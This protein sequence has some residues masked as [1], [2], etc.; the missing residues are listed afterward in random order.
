MRNPYINE[1]SVLLVRSSPVIKDPKELHTILVF[2]LRHLWGDL[3]S[4][5]CDVLVRK[6]RN[7]LAN[8][9]SLAV[10]CRSESVP[11]IRAALTM[12][13]TPPYLDDT[14]YRFDVLEIQEEGNTTAEES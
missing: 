1:R 4:H 13:T 2:S 11:A 5:S 3:E 8:D 6:R 7:D 14:L 10:H 9:A 12:V